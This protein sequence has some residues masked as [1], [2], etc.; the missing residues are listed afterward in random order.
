MFRFL[1]ECTLILVLTLLGAAFSLYAGLMPPPWKKPELAGGEIQ[2][3]D[4]QAMNVIWVDARSKIDY[5]SGH[6]D[7]ALLLNDSN[8]EDG[9]QDLMSVWLTNMRPI[10]V[11]CSSTQCNSSKRTAKQLRN[12]LP[13]AEIYSLK[14]DWKKWER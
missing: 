4:A 8:W 10:V 1:K 7:G 9:I 2:L 14:G 6:I 12:A 11:Y 13:E 5:D 3:Q